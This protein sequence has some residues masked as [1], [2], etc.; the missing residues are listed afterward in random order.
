MFEDEKERLKRKY[1]H[2]KCLLA[3]HLLAKYVKDLYHAPGFRKKI[4]IRGKNNR[5]PHVPEG[6]RVEITGNDNTVEIDPSVKIYKGSI[7]IGDL[8]SPAS[9][10]TVRIGKNCTSNGVNMALMEDASRIIIGDDC[11]FSWGIN[12]YVSDFHA[13]YPSGSKEIINKGR[14]LMIGNHVWI[15][16]HVTVLKNSRVA[17]NS[18][19]GAHAVVAKKFEEENCVLAGNPARVVKRKINWSRDWPNRC[20]ADAR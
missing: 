1:G 2:C 10:C 6:L 9:G 7:T 17:D 15:A 13:L 16:M 14:E 11:M 4:I 20:R 3:V 8:Y 19:V 18:V 5:C 12:F